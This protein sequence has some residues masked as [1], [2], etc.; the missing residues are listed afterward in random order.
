MLFIQFFDLDVQLIG[1]SLVIRDLTLDLDNLLLGF[2]RQV[3][4]FI[5]N[6]S[7]QSQNKAC[8]NPEKSEQE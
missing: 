4:V 6:L 5:E 8:G 1:L 7:P 3:S 2:L